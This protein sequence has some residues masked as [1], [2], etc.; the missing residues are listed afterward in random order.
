MGLQAAGIP[1]YRCGCDWGR[2]EGHLLLPDQTKLQLLRM[3]WE[4]R[5]NRDPAKQN[6]RGG[7]AGGLQEAGEQAGFA[8]C[9][10][11]FR[12]IGAGLRV[13]DSTARCGTG[14]G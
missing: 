12:S 3:A 13:K 8:G 14:R 7:C 10:C 6:R 2:L 9:R 1:A 11:V 5:C 4:V